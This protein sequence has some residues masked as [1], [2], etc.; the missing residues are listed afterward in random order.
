MTQT[1]ALAGLVVQDYNVLTR[2]TRNIKDF[3]PWANTPRKVDVLTVYRTGKYPKE[4]VHKLANGVKKYSNADFY[5]LTDSTESFGPDI[6]VI[7]N[8]DLL[9]GWWAKPEIFNPDLPL[10]RVLYIDL[11]VVIVGSLDPLLY[12]NE[13]VVIT[14][15]FY[16]GGPSQSVLLYN[17]G[18]FERTYQSW[19]K[20]KDAFIE[21]GDK[22]IPPDFGDQTLMNRTITPPMK[23]WQDVLPG[24]VLSYKVHLQ[25]YCDLR[26]LSNASIV[27]FHGKPKMNEVND[28]WVK[29]LW[30]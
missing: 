13:Y 14:K 17:V 8:K 26:L 15:D 23:Y 2:L 3:P 29:E 9:P 6:N 12:C 21:I 7:Y 25:P 4:W 28:Q 20:N 24:K 18:M 5:V 19:L 22:C 1:E 10:N 16:F 11:S 27:K 30:I